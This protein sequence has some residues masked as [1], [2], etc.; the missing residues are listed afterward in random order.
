MTGHV[1]P[2]VQSLTGSDVA[3]RTEA[4]SEALEFEWGRFT[5]EEAMDLLLVR[6]ACDRKT[7]LGAFDVRYATDGYRVV[8]DFE[9][10]EKKKK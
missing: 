7:L 3:A 10:D 2:L 4:T 6:R 8:Q 9:S 5:V 1:M